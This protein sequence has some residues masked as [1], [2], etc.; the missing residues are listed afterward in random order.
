MKTIG[1]GVI[2]WG[3]MGKTHTQALRSI[4]LFYP[5]AG[6]EIAL[7]C[8]CARHPENAREG[9]RAAGFEH[10]T[11][12][13]RRL[14]ARDDIDVV[15]ICTP[16]DQHEAMAVAALR[17]GKHVMIDKP[18]AVT[19]EGAERIAA[20]AA[21]S[22]AFTRVMFNSRFL[23]ATLRAR[24]LVDEGRIG[25]V[26]TFNARYLHSGSIDPDKPIGWKQQAQGGVLLDLGSHALDLLTWLAGYP[27]RVFGSTFT[28]YGD[29]PTRDGG[30]ERTLAE[31][32]V[33]ALLQMPGGA[34]GCVEASKIATG[35]NDELTLELRG[36]KGA[37]RFDS[38]DINYLYFYDNTLPEADFG[39]DRGFTR[40]E[41]V[42]RYP[43]PG[44]KF[45]PPKNSLGWERG[46]THC[47]YTFLDA[48]A[49]GVRPEGCDV[50]EAARLQRLMA[51]IRRSEALGTWVS[52]EE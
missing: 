50:A 15:S 4:P 44:G 2:G 35:S 22:G 30:R 48:V 5:G 11:D 8:V 16:N 19:V 7:R 43:A 23:P 36:T 26:L 52:V 40:I 31:D 29:R 46:H 47:Y 37:L 51:D 20:E 10:A 39:G 1:V 34:V 28:L 13:Y 41:S 49:R 33:Q 25:N 27:R 24:Q 18:L 45:L 32:H 12:D 17:A 14:L 9:A 3:F 38:M 6:F 42:A 21:R